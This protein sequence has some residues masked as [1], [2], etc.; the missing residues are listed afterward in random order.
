[1][2]DYRLPLEAIHRS[3]KTVPDICASLLFVCLARGM[4]L[5]AVGTYL[6]V[7]WASFCRLA[8]VRYLVRGWGFT[9][10]PAIY[11]K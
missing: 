2:R 5:R 9:S 7:F 1:M 11:K 8:S 3:P 6:F 4:C 10:I